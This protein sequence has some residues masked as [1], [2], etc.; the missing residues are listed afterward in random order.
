MVKGLGEVTISLD[1]HHVAAG[2]IVCSFEKNSETSNKL[3]TDLIKQVEVE[4]P[5]RSVFKGRAVKMDGPGDTVVPSFLDLRN[6]VK[7]FLNADIE[8]QLEETLFLP[9]ENRE[10]YAKA[11]ISMRRGCI[12]EGQYGTGKSL[13]AYILAQRGVRAK[14]TY[15][16]TRSNLASLG[17]IFASSL[18]P[19]IV[20]I[21]DI[22]AAAHGSR[23]HLNNLLNTVSSIDNKHATEVMLTLSTNFIDRIDPAMLRPGRVNSIVNL[24][25]PNRDTVARIILEFGGKWLDESEA[26]GTFNAACE[27]MAGT[28]PAILCE[29][30]DRCKIRAM[31]LKGRFNSADMM[32]VFNT[33]ARQRE[34]AIPKFVEDDTATTLANSLQTVVKY[35]AD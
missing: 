34:L 8:A 13:L 20:F 12:F 10:E 14:W 18:Q 24:A 29:V 21:E 16:R 33:M 4:I 22:D 32:R 30:I 27:Q 7:L 6:E 1:P 11:G 23:D 25:P 17:M 3:W 19:C 9:I 2:Q 5:K 15:L 35:G 28:T 31:S 26:M